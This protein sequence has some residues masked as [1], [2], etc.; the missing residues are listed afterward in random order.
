MKIFVYRIAMLKSFF[1]PSENREDADKAMQEH[2]EK[3]YR[4]GTVV[5][6]QKE[7][8]FET[9]KVIEVR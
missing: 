8:L 4:P 1:V 6:F 3:K 7:V 2:L 5:D 9:G